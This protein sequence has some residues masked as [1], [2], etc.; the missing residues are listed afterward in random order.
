MPLHVHGHTLPTTDSGKDILIQL[1]TYNSHAYQMQT[2]AYIRN[3]IAIIE[4]TSQLITIISSHSYRHMVRSSLLRPEP[5]NL[6]TV[7]QEI[8]LVACVHCAQGPRVWPRSK[9]NLWTTHPDRSQL[10][11]NEGCRPLKWCG[12]NDATRRWIVSSHPIIH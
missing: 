8:V 10:R 1:E 7:C 11:S 6:Q 9:R 12:M 4:V 3:L 2:W 5:E